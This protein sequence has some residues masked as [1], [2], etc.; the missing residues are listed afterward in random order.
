MGYNRDWHKEK[1]INDKRLGKIFDIELADI[2]GVSGSFVSRI[3]T[4]MGIPPKKQINKK[5]WHP[6]RGMIVADELLGHV[7]DC[8]LARKYECSRHLIMAIRREND[9]PPCNPAT[10][11]NPGVTYIPSW[12]TAFF[13]AWQR[14]KGIDSHLKYLTEVRKASNVNCS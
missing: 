5:H 10:K 9:I 3:R 1:L 11:N 12:Q 8:L 13:N 6:M 2:Y 7:P 4:S 14:P